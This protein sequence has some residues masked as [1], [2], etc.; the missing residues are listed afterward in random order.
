MWP[1]IVILSLA[2]EEHDFPY[3]MRRYK[4]LKEERADS[5]PLTAGEVQHFLEADPTE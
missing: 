5:N 1:L 4:T 3:T 2:A